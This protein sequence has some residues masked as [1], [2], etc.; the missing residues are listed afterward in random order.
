LVAGRRIVIGY[1]EAPW[2]DYAR[3]PRAVRSRS[4]KEALAL[5]KAL[6]AQLR[7][8]RENF[9]EFVQQYS[10]HADAE[11]GGDIGVWSNRERSPLPREIEILATL[12]VGGISE[13]LDSQWG[14]EIL[15]R[16]AADERQ[17]YAAAAIKITFE[18]TLPDTDER[19]RAK[20]LAR[21]RSIGTLLQEDPAL[22]AAFQREY[23]CAELERW[24]KGSEPLGAA[25]I[26]DSLRFGETA[27]QPL[28]IRPQFVILRRVD[29]ALVPVPPEAVFEIPEP[30]APNLES[31]VR[32][33][34]PVGLAKY[35]RSLGRDGAELLKLN[36]DRARLFTRVHESLA[37]LFE[38]AP[39]F[40][41]RANALHQ[42]FAE[43]KE[44][45]PPEDFDRYVDFVN[46]R[47]ASQV[48][49]IPDEQSGLRWPG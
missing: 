39:E 45:L 35:V 3:R 15:Q 36:G 9:A 31:L 6:S 7:A 13:P 5:G 28:E 46:R 24:G 19:S 22:F 12:E 27:A 40:D 32:R 48:L 17:Q 43:L 41:A 25:P 14:I 11:R 30:S 8:A 33:T 29:P 21:A 18:D 10:D 34:N 4:R 23:C 1:K 44:A 20:S 42:A 38:A 49:G 2:L 47:I 16:T 37:T 26:L